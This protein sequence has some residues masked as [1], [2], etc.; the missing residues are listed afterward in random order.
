MPRP[1]GLPAV[2]QE[3][4]LAAGAL[5]PL[6]PPLDDDPDEDDPDDDDPDEDDPD[7][8]EEPDDEPEDDPDDAPEDDPESPPED[9][10]DLA[11]LPAVPAAVVSAVEA[12]ESVR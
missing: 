8:E 6:D 9:D 4:E 3:V 10:S 1:T 2:G 7:D 5:P 12:R 11:G